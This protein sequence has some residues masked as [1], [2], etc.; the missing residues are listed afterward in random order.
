MKEEFVGSELDAKKREIRNQKNEELVDREWKE[1]M[2][3]PEEQRAK[4][5]KKLGHRLETTRVPG[6]TDE[7]FN[8]ANHDIFH[9]GMRILAKENGVDGPAF[10]GMLEKG[11]KSHEIKNKGSAQGVLGGFVDMLGIKRSVKIPGII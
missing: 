5:Q 9:V 6:Q 10:Y 7:E 2:R 4:Y 3:L 1:Y 8:K 11:F